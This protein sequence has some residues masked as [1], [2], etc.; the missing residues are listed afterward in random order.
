M[1][2]AKIITINLSDS[3]NEQFRQHFA[4]ND[5]YMLACKTMS[6]ALRI[7]DIEECRLIIYSVTSMS[8]VALEGVQRI[9][10]RSYA[11]IL[12][13]AEESTI[14]PII[15]VGAVICIQ[16]EETF[17]LLYSQAISMIQERES[18]ILLLIQA[19]SDAVILKLSITSISLLLQEKK[20]IWFRENFDS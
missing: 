20:S 15:E 7:L 8:N 14:M 3:F 9:R 18:F 17:S 10:E 12:V 6:E 13:F 19:R 1:K 11:P 16:A 2:A 5:Y 4:L